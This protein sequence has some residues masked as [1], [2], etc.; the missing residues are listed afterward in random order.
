MLIGI[1]LNAGNDRNGN[2]RRGWAITDVESG[3]I[4]D[5]VDE[6]YRGVGAFNRAYPDVTATGRIM[7]TPGEYREMKKFE[8]E[9]R[10]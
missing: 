3:D 6:G 2:P 4:I 8:K 1:Y 7:T 10:D 5:F 9:P